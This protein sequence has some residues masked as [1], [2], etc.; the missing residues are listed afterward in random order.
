MTEKLKIITG[1]DGASPFSADG[2]TENQDGTFEVR[3]SWRSEPGISEDALG[4]GSS[5]STRVKNTTTVQQQFD[6]FINWQDTTQQRL[7]YHD[8]VMV[9]FPDSD[10]WDIV[11]VKLRDGGA[12]LSIQLPPG[13]THI[14][15]SPWY[16]Y[17]TAVDYVNSK[18]GLTGVSTFSAGKSN[19]G[20]KIP[21]LLIDAPNGKN[22]KQDVMII[23]RN[24]AYESAGSFCIEGMVNDL[25]SDSPTAQ[26]LLKKYRFHFLPMTNP[27]GVHNG[28]SRLTAP[29]G[30]DLNRSIEQPDAAWQA[31]KNYIDKVKP[32]YLLNIHHWMDKE[33]DGLLTNTKAD[34]ERFR[35]LM[36]DL[37]EDKHYWLL[38][39]TELY[40]NKHGFD[41]CPEARK[42]W[43]DYTLEK[44]GTLAITLEFPWFN[45]TTNRMRKIGIQALDALLKIKART[46]Y[47]GTFNAE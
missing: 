22:A 28:L 23:A 18:V 15:T 4:S 43:K 16:G 8:F 6:C 36:P 10:E 30:A 29:N 9:K 32:Q 34:A 1:F 33:K 26:A 37:V 42:S 24:H 39:W 46:N 38:E 17:H 12:E 21:V 35:A 19:E 47:D 45:R 7:N 14:G 25:L 40:L 5:F 44:F 27:D 13:I 3:P 41:T 31:L 11:M 2:V 20:R